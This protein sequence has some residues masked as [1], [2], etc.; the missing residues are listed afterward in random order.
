VRR[1]RPPTPLPPPPTHTPCLQAALEDKDA[2]EKLVVRLLPH[3]SPRNLAVGDVVAFKSPLDTSQASYM[4]GA[5][6]LA[7]A[8]VP[9]G[10]GQCTG[11]AGASTLNGH[12]SLAE[13]VRWAGG[14]L[15]SQ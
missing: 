12:P 3:P 2:Y 8:W 4:V 11:T 6:V 10:S 7:A 9:R 15:V 5:A 13:G 14:R 1:A